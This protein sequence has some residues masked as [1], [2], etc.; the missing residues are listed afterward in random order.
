MGRWRALAKKLVELTSGDPYFLGQLGWAY[1]VLGHKEEAQRI[2]K[3]LLDMPS[4]QPASP[5]AVYYVYMGLGDRARAR[6]WMEKAYTGRWSDVVWIKSAPEYDGLRDDP[7]FQALLEK[8][9]LAA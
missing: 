8:L 6:D 3:Q 7:R 1:G 9:G 5:P 4:T 2:L